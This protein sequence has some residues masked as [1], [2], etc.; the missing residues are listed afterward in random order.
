MILINENDEKTSKEVS[1]YPLLVF[2]DNKKANLSIIRKV[3]YSSDIKV[4]K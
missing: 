2:F 4:Q 1:Y 3:S